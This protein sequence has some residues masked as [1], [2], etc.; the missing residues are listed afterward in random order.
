MESS[1]LEFDS[2]VAKYS[3][4]LDHLPLEA[5]NMVRALEALLAIELANLE[6]NLLGSQATETLSNQEEE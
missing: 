3:E 5:Q 2:L 1:S 4:L 6:E